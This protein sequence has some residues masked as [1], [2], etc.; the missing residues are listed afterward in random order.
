MKHSLEMAVQDIKKAV[1]ETPEEEK[2]DN[3]GERKDE[4]SPSQEATFHCVNSNG[5][6]SACHGARE[7]G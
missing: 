2:R 1:G 6:S 7:V 3:Q 5:Q 4:L